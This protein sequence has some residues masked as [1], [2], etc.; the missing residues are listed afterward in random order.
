[1][2]WRFLIQFIRVE[3]VEI[4]VGFFKVSTLVI[5]LNSLSESAGWTKRE[6]DEEWLIMKISN[7]A[8]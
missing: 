4:R 2:G 8:K 3:V 7:K 5:T 1:L 6:L